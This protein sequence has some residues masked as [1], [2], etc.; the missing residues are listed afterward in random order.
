MKKRKK[1]RER[2]S[3]GVEVEREKQEK[4]LRICF[5]INPVAGLGGE[6]GFKGSDYIDPVKLLREK[7]N[8]IA[9]DKAERFLRSLDKY[10]DSIEIITPQDPMGCGIVS[11]YKHK[12]RNVI[13]V[14]LER[15]LV[16]GLS[17][18]YH[19]IEFIEKYSS[20]CDVIVFVGGDGT[21]RDVLEGLSRVNQLS[22]AVLGVPAG[23]KVY[24]GV[25]ARSPETA[26]RV[27]SYLL[28][29]L[30]TF[31]PVDRPVVDADEIDLNRGVLNMRNYGFLKTLYIEDLVQ[32][33]KSPSS[34]YRD[35]DYEGVARY[36]EEIFSERRDTLFIVGPGG[37]LKRVFEYL[38]IDKTPYGVDAFYEKKIVGRDLSRK[39][40][41]SLVEAYEKINIILTPIPGTRYLIGR[42]NQ[43]ISPKAYE[44]AGRDG[45]IIITSLSKLSGK[46]VVYIDTGDPGLDKRL[47]GYIR[48]VIGYRE[49]III[50]LVP[51]H[52]I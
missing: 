23:V 37:T 52:E 19:T 40:V 3:R 9:Y 13:C 43:Q 10:S 18:R 24:S 28:E 50:R 8:L 47:A 20:Y 31:E 5:F 17:N 35:L 12:F 2:R 7:Y 1:E 25:F 38:N 34:S 44:K 49:E 33:S 42:G 26:S 4:M 27:I 15:E 6:A 46:N 36:I 51:A 32:E 30:N 48:A 45:L 21:A 22:K 29:N 11:K 41:D 16:N 14:D 39:E